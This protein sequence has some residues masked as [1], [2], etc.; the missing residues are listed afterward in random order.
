[1]ALYSTG[2][3]TGVA[4]MSGHSRTKSVPIIDGNVI[5]HAIKKSEIGGRALDIYLAKLYG[6]PLQGRAGEAPSVMNMLK[7]SEMKVAHCSVASKGH[8]TTADRQRSTLVL[9]DGEIVEPPDW[10]KNHVPELL[11]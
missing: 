2:R 3:R 9:P 5:S 8:L 7:M 10:V 6:L 11:F 1:M 4:L